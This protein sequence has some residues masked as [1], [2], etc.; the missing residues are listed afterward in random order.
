MAC[1]IAARRIFET[2]NAWYA[3]QKILLC[4]I[5]GRK[6]QPKIRR[7]EPHSGSSDTGFLK[8]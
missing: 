2:G 7:P 6:A 5:A 4:E 1:A 8:Q 3:L